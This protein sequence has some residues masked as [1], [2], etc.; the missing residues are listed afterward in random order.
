VFSVY[1]CICVMCFCVFGVFI[2]LFACMWG[3][4]V[5]CVCECLGQVCV[6]FFF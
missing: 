2:W 4:F 5:R 1:W 6:C 3:R